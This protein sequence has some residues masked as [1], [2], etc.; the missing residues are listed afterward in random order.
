MSDT[1]S[2]LI[3]L[4]RPHL[5]LVPPDAPIQLDDDLGRL[6]LDSLESI[7]VLMEIE[8]EFGIPIPDD[9]ITVETLATPGN[10]LR[11]LEEQLALIPQA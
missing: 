8:T 5:R 10:L 2:R 3:A 9:L 4:L 6:G 11:V 7:E 1:A